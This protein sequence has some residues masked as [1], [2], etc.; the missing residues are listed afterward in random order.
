MFQKEGN[1][2]AFRNNIIAQKKPF[3]NCAG[4]FLNK[5]PYKIPVHFVNDFFI[6]C[7]MIS[8]SPL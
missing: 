5:L 7:E 8:N 4:V 3:V 1:T 2:V 6:T